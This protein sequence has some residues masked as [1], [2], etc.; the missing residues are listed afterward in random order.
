MPRKQTDTYQ[1]YTIWLHR[2][3]TQKK[4]TPGN[5]PRRSCTFGRWSPLSTKTTRRSRQRHQHSWTPL[6]PW[7]SQQSSSPQNGN[8]DD[9]Q[10]ALRSAPRC[11][12]RRAKRGDK[13]EATKKRRQGG[14]RVSA[15]LRARS[16]RVAGDL[17][18]WRR[19]RRGACIVVDQDSSILE[20]LHSTLI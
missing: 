12:R 14:I 13:E 18:L 5:L 19:E 8:K 4:R 10:E 1:D 15:V 17:S 6:R 3:I 2:K 9:Q 7:P 20:E 11:A 16:R